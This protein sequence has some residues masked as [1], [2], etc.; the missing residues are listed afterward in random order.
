MQSLTEISHHPARQLLIPLQVCAP[1]LVAR[2]AAQQLLRGFPAHLKGVAKL[3][4]HI[5][6]RYGQPLLRQVLVDR[7][8]RKQGIL[9]MVEKCTIANQLI[10]ISVS[11]VVYSHAL[12]LCKPTRPMQLCQ[13]SA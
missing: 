4:S 2:E 11:R 10:V 6:G 1:P 12:Y 5:P 3:P 13:A 8:V 7:C 9:Q